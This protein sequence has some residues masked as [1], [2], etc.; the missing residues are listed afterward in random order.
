MPITI[1]E[2]VPTMIQMTLLPSACHI[3]GSVN[4]LVK[5]SRPMNGGFGFTP[6]KS[7]TE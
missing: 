4:I 2:I 5:L 7:T 6:L 3:F 1:G